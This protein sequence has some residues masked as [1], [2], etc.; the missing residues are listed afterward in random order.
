MSKL[1]TTVKSLTAIINQMKQETAEVIGSL[2]EQN[3][4]I[5]TV[6]SNPHVFTM[7]SASLSKDCVLDPFYYNWEA[8]YDAI[9]AKLNKQSLDTFAKTVSDICK[10]QRLDGRRLHPEVIARISTLIEE[11]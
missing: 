3:P 1:N 2:R 6:N 4:N 10:T 11:A 9:L 5:T 7:S 8:Q